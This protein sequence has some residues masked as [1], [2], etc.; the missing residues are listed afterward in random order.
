MAPRYGHHPRGQPWELAWER[1]LR[2]DYTPETERIQ[3]RL[4]ATLP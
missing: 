1:S 4:N 3:L 2:G